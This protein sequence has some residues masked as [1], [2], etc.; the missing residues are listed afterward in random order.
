[1][2]RPHCAASRRWWHASPRPRKC[3]RRSP[4]RWG[5]SWA[6]SARRCGGMR[7]T[8]PPRSP[9]AGASWPAQRRSV[10]DFAWE[11]KTSPRRCSGP[12]GRRASTDYADASGTIGEAFMALGV[13]AGVGAP[14]IVDGRLWGSLGAAAAEPLPPDAESR[15]VEFSRAGRPRDRE[16][17]GP[18]G[19]HRVAGADRGRG[20]RGT[21]A[22]GARP[23]RRRA[24]AARAHRDHAQAGAAGARARRRRRSVARQRGAPARG[25]RQP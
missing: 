12:R 14:I 4:R 25:A 16:R 2:S 21:T 23:A 3:S 17:R 20:S 22:G 18:H 5:S 6:S 7:T 13:R 9:P 10:A 15:I 24:A 8:T 19:A 11:A 1:M